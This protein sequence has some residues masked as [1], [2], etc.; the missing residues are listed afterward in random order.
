MEN[1]IAVVSDKVGNVNRKG[2]HH[3]SIIGSPL[4][5][6]TS[7]SNIVPPVL[8]ITLGIVLKLFEMIL[9]EVR[10]LDR[11]HITA[12]Q[13]EIEKEWKAERKKLKEKKNDMYNLC[14]KLLDMVNF[15]EGFAKNNLKKIFQNKTRLLKFVVVMSKNKK[16]NLAVDFFVWRLNLMTN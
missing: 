6:I 13:K 4:I 9:S 3:S 11:N 1:F 14:H 7:L 10:K 5:P 2:K 15:K 8:H 16:Y 12:A